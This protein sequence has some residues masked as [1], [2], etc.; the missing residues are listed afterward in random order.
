MS[1]TVIPAPPGGTPT[2][3]YR[4]WFNGAPVAAA[5]FDSAVRGAIHV[6]EIMDYSA[7]IGPAK[8]GQAA[9]EQALGM[10]S[11][12]PSIVH[13]GPFTAEAGAHTE[14]SWEIRIRTNQ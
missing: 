14:H 12:Q 6:P 2:V 1:R 4:I 13:G 5:G 3:R 8:A 10:G 11:V 9:H 7:Y